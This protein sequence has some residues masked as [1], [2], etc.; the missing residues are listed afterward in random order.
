MLRSRQ[1]LNLRKKRRRGAVIV[2]FT[3]VF[4]LFLVVVVTLME[5]GRAMWTYATLAHATRQVARFCMVRG[6]ENPATASDL[7]AV[8]DRQCSSSGLD[9]SKVVVTTTWN[10]DPTPASISRGDFVQ[11]QLTYPFRFVTAPL[12]LADNSLQLSSTCRM[13]VAN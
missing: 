4:M 9:S 13:V 8:V 3:L 1:R 6:S 10:D 12:L 7:Q 5:F 2:E 11:V